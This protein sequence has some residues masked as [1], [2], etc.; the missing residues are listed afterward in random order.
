MLEQW[1][2]FSY[3]AK[4]KKAEKKN[5]VATEGSKDKAQNKKESA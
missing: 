3:L 5:K 1:N 4:E 2:E